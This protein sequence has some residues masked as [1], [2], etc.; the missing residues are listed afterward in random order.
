MKMKIMIS[1]IAFCLINFCF[2]AQC[3][4]SSYCEARE[5]CCKLNNKYGC[6]PYP[7]ATC[8]D[9]GSHCCPNGY[10]C[11]TSDG[12]CLR[13]QGANEFLSYVYLFEGLRPSHDNEDKLVELEN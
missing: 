8:C 4:D 1:L 6:C 10:R 12:Y 3:P 5:T 13:S 7:Y 11:N 9:D 2:N